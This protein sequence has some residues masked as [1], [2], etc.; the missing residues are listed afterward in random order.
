MGQL[1]H[2]TDK[3]K[4]LG[5]ILL[6]YNLATLILVFTD[7]YSE[8]VTIDFTIF[9]FDIFGYKFEFEKYVSERYN[10]FDYFDYPFYFL[11]A[12]FYFWYWSKDF[13]PL[14]KFQLDCF[15]TTFFFV[16]FKFVHQEYLHLSFWQLIITAYCIVI[17]FPLGLWIARNFNYSRFKK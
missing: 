6:C 8:V 2:Q 5:I 15:R 11:G 3:L 10:F 4:R 1:S 14:T 9:N 13:K 7:W 16:A 12:I 17:G